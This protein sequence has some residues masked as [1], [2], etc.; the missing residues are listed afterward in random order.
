MRQKLRSFD[1]MEQAVERRRSRSATPSRRNFRTV[2][3]DSTPSN[4]QSKN[5]SE[6]DCEPEDLASGG[7]QPS[8]SSCSNAQQEALQRVRK[9]AA[10]RAAERLKKERDELLQAELKRRQKEQA[11]KEKLERYSSPTSIEELRNAAA[12]ST[13]V[14]DERRRAAQEKQKAQQMRV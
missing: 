8:R 10:K 14:A 3:D 9:E 1:G 12:G 6:M 5:G 4:L 7:Q 13:P 11:Q 2:P